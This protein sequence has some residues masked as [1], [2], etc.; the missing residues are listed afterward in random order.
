M[1]QV[2]GNPWWITIYSNMPIVLALILKLVTKES[3]F[4]V[5]REILTTQGIN[6]DDAHQKF[7]VK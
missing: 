1:I 2:G 6:I 7:S 4:C 3:L 5:A